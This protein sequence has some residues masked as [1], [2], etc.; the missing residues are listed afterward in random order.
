MSLLPWPLSQSFYCAV[1]LSLSSLPSGALSPPSSLP[2]SLCMEGGDDDKGWRCHQSQC[3]TWV[4][5]GC[6]SAL[7][8]GRQHTLV[9]NITES[10]P[11]QVPVRPNLTLPPDTD[12]FP[13]SSFV[14]ISF[15]VGFGS[16]CLNPTVP[17]MLAPARQKLCL[18]L[19]LLPPCHRGCGCIARKNLC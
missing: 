11:P 19:S 18:F 14:S 1:G 17:Q 12:Q 15:Q 4:S 13:F 3:L 5:P 2:R 6:H 7:S 8:A 16:S 10:M 9:Q